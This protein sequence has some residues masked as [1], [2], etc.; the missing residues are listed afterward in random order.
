MRLMTLTCL[1]LIPGLLWAQ[2][3]GE[4]KKAAADMSRRLQKQFGLTKS[5]TAAFAKTPRHLFVPPKLQN[6]A[7]TESDVPFESG[8]ES[9]EVYLLPSPDTYALLFKALNIRPKEKVLILGAHAGYAAL[10][11][12][13]LASRVF[14]IETSPSSHALLVANAAPN[15]SFRHSNK[16]T[17]FAFQGP[18]DVILVHGALD[19]FPDELSGQAVKSGGRI[20]CALRD[21]EGFQ[22]FLFMQTGSKGIRA[23]IIGDGFMNEINL[24]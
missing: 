18:F 17:E 23:S 7:Y 1:V 12:S 6:I 22:H 13:H 3:T 16:A 8:E 21:K 4:Q 2:F 14:L 5:L 20:L 9:A 24:R 11:A 10:L 19:S 15:I